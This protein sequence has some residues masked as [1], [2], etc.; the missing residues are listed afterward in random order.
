M[1][2]GSRISIF[3][4]YAARYWG[5]HAA[6]HIDA[7]IVE[8]IK[9][10]LSKQDHAIKWGRVDYTEDHSTRWTV[11]ADIS[12]N[13]NSNGNVITFLHIIARFGFNLQKT[14]PYM[15]DN[16]IDIIN[17]GAAWTNETPLLLACR[18][19]HEEIIEYLLGTPGICINE[20][21]KREFTALGTAVESRN[22]EIAKRLL[23]QKNIDINGTTDY[24]A[25]LD[26]QLGK[27]TKGITAAALNKAK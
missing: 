10:L 16:I 20:R 19:G 4:K 2:K 17:S 7:E 8:L 26:M 5:T 14:L 12:Y 21:D 27:V 3:Y 24:T 23:T 25:L 15:P 22:F 13:D 6:D 11:Y 9:L 18:Y 1:V